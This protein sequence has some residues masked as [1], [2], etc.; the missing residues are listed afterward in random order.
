MAMGKVM[1]AYVARAANEK[2]RPM[3]WGRRKR[4]LGCYAAS[5]SLLLS[6]SSNIVRN[7]PPQT[8]C[9]LPIFP[10][11]RP[12]SSRVLAPVVQTAVPTSLRP[13]RRH[14]LLRHLVR[15][16]KLP[17]PGWNSERPPPLAYTTLTVAQSH[18]EL[19]RRRVHDS[20]RCNQV[21]T[22]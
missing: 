16:A 6:N 3:T 20:W 15:R 1:R 17:A 13:V 2:P 21:Y 18:G 8:Q 5:S 19:R 4:E 7:I 9:L 22:I 11:R 14:G 12:S 10:L